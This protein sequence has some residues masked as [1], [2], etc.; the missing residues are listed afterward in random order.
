MKVLAIGYS[1]IRRMLR[2]KSNIFFVFIFPIAIILLV[3][4]QFGGG[5]D[6]IVGIY[7]ADD[8]QIA[9]SVVT[10]LE[11]TEGLATR[12]YESPDDLF[13]GVERGQIQAGLT[14]PAGMDDLA[15]S[16]EQVEM[17][18]V[19]R[20]DGAGPQMQSL[21]GAAVADVMRPVGAA[22]FANA[23]T[24]SVTTFDQSLSVALSLGDNV[25][26]PA[27]EVTAVGESLFP[28]DMGQFDLG[29]PSMTVMFV[30]L[31]AMAG[32]AALILTRKLG[33]SQRML[34]TPTPVGAIVVGESVGRWGTAMVQGLYIMI[35]SFLIFGVDWGDPIGAFLVLVTFS[36]VGAGAGVL[37]GSTFAN[38]EQAGGVGV[39]LSIGMAALGGA[40]F[41][42]ELFGETM[43]KVAHATPHAW[44]IDAFSELI[45]H[46]GATG[47]IVFE[48]GVLAL[49]ASVLFALAAWRLRVAITRP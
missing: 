37:M 4:L 46:D 25:Q 33:I 36:A 3:G 10:E 18:F 20:P 45:R 34:S 27:V 26:G 14:L 44:A 22:Q 28:A 30:F 11:N 2:E 38:D 49:Y 47:D 6:P 35:F 43:Q 42:L 29:A 5:F 24:G 48:L 17:G 31:T 19:A 9:E 32:S 41:P 40:M 8:G 1:N 7:Q 23:A 13:A 39:M 21:V 15:R 16:G 12:L